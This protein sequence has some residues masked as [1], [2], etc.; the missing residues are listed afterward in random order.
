MGN[1]NI[2]GLS[3]PYTNRLQNKALAN[4]K[5][6]QTIGRGKGPLGFSYCIN[7]TRKDSCSLLRILQIPLTSIENS[8]LHLNNHFHKITSPCTSTFVVYGFSLLC[9]SDL[10]IT[11]MNTVVITGLLTRQVVIPLRLATF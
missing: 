4:G 9:L 11:F 1:L 2:D 10:D 7:R 6:L 3:A 5:H 8:I